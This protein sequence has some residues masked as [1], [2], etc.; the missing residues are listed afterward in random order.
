[1]ITTST[2]DAHFST[3]VASF[4]L[5]FSGLQRL[6]WRRSPES[7]AGHAP[8]PLEGAV[9]LRTRSLN[10]LPHALEQVDQGPQV[11]SSQSLSHA[12]IPQPSLSVSALQALPP[13]S[14]RCLTCRSLC[15]MP[16]PHLALQEVQ[17][18]HSPMAQFTGQAC[19]LQLFCTVRGGQA[20]PLS[21][22][23]TTWRTRFCTPPSQGLLHSSGV[24]EETSQS[25]MKGRAFSIL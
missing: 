9:A 4:A 13:C 23:T 20:A 15:L 5:H 3:P 11:A 2:F 10:P 12:A 25:W 7:S 18:D 14:E 1:M 24:Q 19:E 16:P 21:S 17:P 8:S 6:Y 22:G